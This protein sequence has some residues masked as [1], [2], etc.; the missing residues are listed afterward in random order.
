MLSDAL[1]ACADSDGAIEPETLKV[2]AYG[3]LTHAH[4]TAFAALSKLGNHRFTLNRILK[5]E[6]SWPTDPARGDELY[7]LA[8]SLRSQLTKE[9]PPSPKN[10]SGSAQELRHNG[11]RLI[12]ELADINEEIA[13]SVIAEDE[14]GRKLPDWFVLELVTQLPRLAAA[15]K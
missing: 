8:G 14:Q 12:L 5:G 9:L 6:E 3:T 2:L 7:F 15:R 10:L 1:N 4:A 11:V 13:Q